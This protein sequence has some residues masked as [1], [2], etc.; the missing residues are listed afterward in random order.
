MR[1]QIRV[2]EFELP[3]SEV[4]RELLAEAR[5]KPVQHLLQLDMHQG[6]HPENDEALTPD[7]DGDCLVISERL[8]LRRFAGVRVQLPVLYDRA[9]AARALHKVAAWLESGID[10]DDMAG[11]QAGRDLDD[12]GGSPIEEV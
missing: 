6:V 7:A 4:R 11:E 9:A 5:T 2:G 10:V 8:E 12:R 1:K 3:E